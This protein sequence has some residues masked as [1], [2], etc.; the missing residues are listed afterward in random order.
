MYDGFLEAISLALLRDGV[1]DVRTAT[2]AQLDAAA[3]F[4]ADAVA[5]THVRFTNDGVE[6]GLPEGSFA[7]H[8]AWS[9]DVLF[10]LGTRRPRVTSTS[11]RSSGSGRP[12]REDRRVRPDG[13]LRAWTALP[14]SRTR[15]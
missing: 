7:A 15:S 4:A 13:G 6:E 2:D 11:A 10:A 12:D 8:Q 3:G 14:S 1:L 5:L 9:G